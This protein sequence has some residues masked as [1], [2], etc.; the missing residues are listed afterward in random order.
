M[1]IL[2]IDDQLNFEIA[3]R[4][5]LKGHTVTGVRDP[6]ALPRVLA[7]EEPFDQ[8]IVDL[9]FPQSTSTGL[10]ALA[11]L[12]ELAPAT[13]T[14]IATTDEEENR[15]LY[16]L[17]AFQFFGPKALLAKRASDYVTRAVVEAVGRGEPAPNPDADSFRNAA[18]L[19]PPL[20]DQVIRNQ[21]ELGIWREL[22][23]FDKR[24]EIA[25]AAHVH[26]RTLDAF[27]ASKSVVIDTVNGRF[28]VRDGAS[29]PRDVPEPAV[30]HS[31]N[32]IKAI[33]FARTHMQFF[34]DAEV[35][36]LL[37]AHWRLPGR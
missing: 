12:R 32:L 15:L 1:R 23:R 17:A 29:E 27:T 19:S 11:Q 13:K 31:A 8:A 21:S 7:F 24:P 33:H 5:I 2:V 37:T 36:A 34:A 16:L 25:N 30:A 10:T 6:T 20:L 18:S 26:P 28:P 35:A 4:D 9:R 22:T 3:L 14:I